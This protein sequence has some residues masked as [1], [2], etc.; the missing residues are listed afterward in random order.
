MTV[1]VNGVGAVLAP[2]VLVIVG[3][4]VMDGAGITAQFQA[5]VHLVAVT[6]LQ[7]VAGPE[8]NGFP[9]ERYLTFTQLEAG[10]LGQVV[11]DPGLVEGKVIPAVVVGGTGEGTGTDAG[12]RAEMPR[13]VAAVVIGIQN[14]RRIGEVAASFVIEILVERGRVEI[15]IGYVLINPPNAGT[16][17]RPSGGRDRCTYGGCREQA[18]C[19]LRKN[20]LSHYGLPSRS[21]HAA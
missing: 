13:T 17:F 4:V 10:V 5:H 18:Q 3:G 12:F 19:G 9:T 20:R 15:R 8:I 11:T 7:A 16:Q 14:Q 1:V 2:V 6:A 21:H